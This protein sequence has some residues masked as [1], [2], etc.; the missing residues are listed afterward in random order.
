M[1]NFIRS[2]KIGTVNFFGVA[3]PGFMLLFFSFIGFFVPV[4]TLALCISNISWNYFESLYGEAKLVLLTIIIIF[5]YIFGYILR[6][7]SP[8]ELDKISGQIVLDKY[9]KDSKQSQ[10]NQK[11]PSLFRKLF[12]KSEEV[13]KNPD[14]P[15]NWE[16]D[17]WPLSNEDGDKYPYY[18]FYRYLEKRNLGDAT[19]ELVTWG[20]PNDGDKFQRSK[21]AVN[22]MKM[23]VILYCPELAGL[24]ES[25]EAHIRLMAGTWTSIIYTSKLILT[26]LI[27]SIVALVLLIVQWILSKYFNLTLPIMI[28]ENPFFLINIIIVLSLYNIMKWAREKI[29]SLFHYRRVSELFFIVQAAVYA[30]ER[31]NNNKEKQKF[32]CP[33]WKMFTEYTQQSN[34]QR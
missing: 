8:D 20:P 34:N 32:E 9:R 25:N 16:D 23:D 27:I 3:I 19:K 6:L 17:G 21:T 29:E 28:H 14:W 33:L 7:T 26:G 5:A 18:Y 13:P 31:K 30:N 1:L 10:N 12:K 22:K 24:I 15:K 11:S 4:I 2:L